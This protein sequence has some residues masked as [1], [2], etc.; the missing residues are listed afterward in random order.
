MNRTWK[1]IACCAA[2]GAWS[3]ALAEQETR[4]V[5]SSDGVVPDNFGRAVAID[6]SL[7]AV[8][9]PFADISGVTDQGAVYVFESNGVGGWNQI[10]KIVA[11]DGVAS[12]QLGGDVAIWGDTIVA[13]AVGAAVGANS[14]EGAAYVFRRDQGG[15]NNWGQVKKLLASTAVLNL[16]E[17]GS[18]V[19]IEGDTIAVGAR[20]AYSSSEG[21]VFLYG[22]NQGSTDNW[23]VVQS[24]QDDV[25]DSNASFGKDVALAGDVLVVGAEL[26]DKVPGS[27]NNEGGIYIF[28]RSAGTWTQSTKRNASDATGGSN[29]G[30]S[31]GIDGDVIVVGAP[32]AD[33]AGASSG[34]AYILERTGPNPGDWTE[35]RVLAPSDPGL[36]AFFGSQVSVLGNTVVVGATG[37]GGTGKGYRFDH[38]GTSWSETT[39]FTASDA[40]A[41]DT[42]GRASAITPQVIALGS[43]LGD[44][45]AVYLYPTGPAG[46]GSLPF[47]SLRLGKSALPEH[48]VLSWSPGCARDVED[49]GIYEGVLGTWYSHTSVTCVDSGT[50]LTE[51]ILAGVGN[52]YYLVVPHS[53]AE[54]G[55]YGS[56]SAGLDRPTGFSA[57]AAIQN[58]ASCP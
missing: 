3:I 8:G 51:D 50:D 26:L 9:A 36:F 4:I 54:E 49:Y 31:V 33:P 52:R 27:F 10:K 40:V 29:F 55:S 48:V 44:L 39:T 53:A 34:S 43:P 57:C 46:P 45:G 12:D 25:S 16:A 38:G 32:F 24:L 2:L 47:N 30:Y 42:L 15:T 20:T 13:G 56:D 28:T 17:V 21:A 7:M 11:P 35:T 18:S 58:I 37:T 23:G 5:R 14:S 41:G 6:G 19:D 1:W 22:R